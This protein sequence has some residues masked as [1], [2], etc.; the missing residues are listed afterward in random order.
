MH[1]IESVPIANK[2]IPEIVT[3]F[4]TKLTEQSPVRLAHGAA[5]PLPLDV[6]SL[7]NG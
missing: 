1:G 3:D 2:P 6:V 4:V 5:T 7:L